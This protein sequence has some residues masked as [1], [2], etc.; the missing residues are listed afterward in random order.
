ML[1]VLA[2]TDKKKENLHIDKN[3]QLLKFLNH[4]KNLKIARILLC[5]FTFLSK[6]LTLIINNK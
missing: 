2:Q 1:G 4:Y 6:Y 3:Y 5:Q